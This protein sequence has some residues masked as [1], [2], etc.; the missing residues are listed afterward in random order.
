M[1]ISAILCLKWI[2][3]TVSVF[4]YTKLWTSIDQSQLDVRLVEI[5][6][7]QYTFIPKGPTKM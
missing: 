5:G 3:F 7:Y 2:Y 4:Q 1:V 6:K